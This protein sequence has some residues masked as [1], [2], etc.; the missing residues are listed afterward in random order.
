MKAAGLVIGAIL[1]MLFAAA[2]V[3]FGGCATP[4]P[5]PPLPDDVFAG[6]VVDCGLPE[7][8]GQAPYARASVRA[9]LLEAAT[10]ACLVKAADSYRVD[11]IACVVRAE[12]EDSNQR[13]LSGDL[14]GDATTVDGA[15]RMWIERE[16]IS[17]RSINR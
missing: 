13:V 10:S 3:A 12:G 15:A 1:G 4:G 17:Y 14:A 7:V 6:A 8:E 5:V 2:V 16:R 9:C 11:T